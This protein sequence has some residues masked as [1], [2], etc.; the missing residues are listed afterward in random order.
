MPRNKNELRAL[1][2]AIV[3]SKIFINKR[4]AAIWR[5]FESSQVYYVD[6]VKAL[7][8]FCMAKRI[9]CPDYVRRVYAYSRYAR[10]AA[11]SLA[12]GLPPI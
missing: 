11:F 2:G 9:L 3:Y 12:P 8:M 4:T 1:E 5:S 7:H 6:T 10:Q